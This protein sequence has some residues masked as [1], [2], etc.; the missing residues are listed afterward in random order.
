MTKIEAIVKLMEDNGGA[1]SLKYI[2]EN[3]TKYYPTAKQ[4]AEW[5]AGLRGVL[6]REK[7]NSI[8]LKKSV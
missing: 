3:I 1:A 8:Y 2:Y 7:K 4:S 5:E 6:Y